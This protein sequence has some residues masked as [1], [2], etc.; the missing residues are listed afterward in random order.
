[1]A[2]ELRMVGTPALNLAFSPVR[3]NNIVRFL[4]FE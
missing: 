3:R 1:M 2:E 4:F